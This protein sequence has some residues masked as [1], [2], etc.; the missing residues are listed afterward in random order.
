MTESK[1]QQEIFNYYNNN[2]CLKH[3]NHRG[4]IFAVPNG[5]TRNKIEAIT[6]KST[7]TLKG[8]SDLIVTLPNG[9]L[10]Y[11][12]IKTETGKQSPEQIDFQK[13]VEDLGYDYYL[14][15]NLY[16]FKEML[17]NNKIV[18]Y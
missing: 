5:G 13:R 15:R 7:G 3:H 12:E 17:K 18:V 9:K 4:L 16:K 2:Y 11:I 8:V 6:L 1:I 10:V 14:I